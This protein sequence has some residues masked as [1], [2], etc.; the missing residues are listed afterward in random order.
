VRRQPD[1]PVILTTGYVEAAAR[2]RDGEFHLLLK[3]YTLEAL[4]EALGV[5]VS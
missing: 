1:L 3:P 2:M 4:A 5:E